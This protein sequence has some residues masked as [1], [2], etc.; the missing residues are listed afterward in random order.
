MSKR[1]AI[2]SLFL[3]LSLLV[4]NGT[5]TYAAKKTKLSATKKTVNVGDTATI[6]LLNNSKTVKWQTSNKNIKITKK[7]K[8]QAKIKALKKG[9][10]VLRAKVGSKTYK[11]NITIKASNSTSNSNEDN[12][13][14]K[15]ARKNITNE[16]FKANGYVIT[17]ST[18]NYDCP[19][20]I[21]A[22]CTFY[23]GLGNAV[24]YHSDSVGFIEKGHTCYLKFREPTVEYTRYEV[25][26]E[27]I[28]GMKYFYHKS[29]ID[30]IS[31]TEN[32]IKSDSD[33]YIMIT[34]TNANP[35]D[36]YYLEV[37]VIYYDENNNI[38]D[39]DLASLSPK[40]NSSETQKIYAPYDR[41]TYKDLEYSRYEVGL[42]YGYHLGK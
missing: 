27:Y 5:T 9:K 40:A 14:E 28:Q 11:C 41:N 2:L 26:Y 15:D 16:T 31:I 25:E 33:N 38:I 7:S 24:D 39:V 22:K 35:Y 8:K 37:A 12:F 29:V 13:N 34:A 36:C 3:L 23:D 18:S 6:K 20:Q 30:K 42:T 19:T 1:K 17:K 10:S 32:L 4:I 21:N